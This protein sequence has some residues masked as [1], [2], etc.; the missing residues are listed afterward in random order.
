V[1]GCYTVVEESDGDT[2]WRETCIAAHLQADIFP[3][4]SLPIQLFQYKLSADKQG[5]SI[6]GKQ[7]AGAA[8]KGPGL[9]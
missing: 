5:Q 8:A 7:R 2:H 1:G 6:K 3:M 9:I 4:K